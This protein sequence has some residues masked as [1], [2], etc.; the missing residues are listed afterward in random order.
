VREMNNEDRLIYGAP[1]EK[2]AMEILVERGYKREDLFTLAPDY[3]TEN[4]LKNAKTFH[5]GDSLP[6]YIIG[7]DGESSGTATVDAVLRHEIADAL[8]QIGL[9]CCVI[10]GTLYVPH[11]DVQEEWH[12]TGKKKWIAD[13]GYT[14]D[15]SPR[16][17][18]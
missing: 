1:L 16:G 9:W 13:M 3:T 12:S 8:R 6:E 2:R 11:R 4:F 17:Y 7:R 14:E 18:H 15:D 5:D 10:E